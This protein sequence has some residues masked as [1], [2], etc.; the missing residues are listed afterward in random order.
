[1]QTL[2]SNYENISRMNVIAYVANKI[3]TGENWL[4]DQAVW[5]KMK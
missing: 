1:M 2:V 3:F 4:T 5:L